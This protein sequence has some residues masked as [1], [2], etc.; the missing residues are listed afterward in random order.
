MLKKDSRR[1]FDPRHW[2]FLESTGVRLRIESMH[3]DV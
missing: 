1:R 3:S 2:V